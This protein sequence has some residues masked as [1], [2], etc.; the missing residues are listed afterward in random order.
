MTGTAELLAED[1]AEE[2][3]DL[4]SAQV[5]LLEDIEVADLEDLSQ[6]LLVSST[7]GTGEVPE[8]SKELFNNL[9]EQRPNL[10][11][12]LYGVISLGDRT[13]PKTFARGGQLWDELLLKCNACRVGDVLCLDA[14]SGE[15]PLDASSH[16]FKKWL[17]ALEE[18][19]SSGRLDKTL[20]RASS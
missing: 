12:L 4:C 11:G 20:R 13:Y 2:N 14:S 7:Y 9:D 5:R 3:E 17:V 15:D 10:N 6:V 19:L 8:P 16:W 18:R 1:L